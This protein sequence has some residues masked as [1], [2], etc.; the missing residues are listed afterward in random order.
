MPFSIISGNHSNMNSFCVICKSRRTSALCTRCSPSH[1]PAFQYFIRCIDCADDFARA[2]GNVVSCIRCSESKH[3]AETAP[4]GDRPNSQIMKASVARLSFL[5]VLAVGQDHQLR[6]KQIDMLI[7]TPPIHP[8]H[9]PLL[10]P[11]LCL[12]WLLWP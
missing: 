1:S 10:P 9:P 2:D 6:R 12:S 3:E 4:C 8:Y 7:R 5:F 11:Y